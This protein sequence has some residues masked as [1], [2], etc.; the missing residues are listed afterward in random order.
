MNRMPLIALLLVIV[1][2]SDN[3]EPSE[4][5]SES[6]ASGRM[7]NANINVASQPLSAAD[8]GEQTVLKTSEYLEIPP[9]ATADLQNG[10]KQAQICRACHSFEAG[11]ASMIGPALHGFFGQAAAS[12]EG[13]RY[14]SAMTDAEFVWT[15]AALDAWLAQPAD[16]LPGNAMTFAGINNRQH[17]IDLIAYLLATTGT[18]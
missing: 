9:Y 10:E 12:V 11:G 14:S 16:F 3:Q 15:P 18:K 5:Q 2:C 17:R 13:F 8:L 6:S 1:G 7:E 4:S